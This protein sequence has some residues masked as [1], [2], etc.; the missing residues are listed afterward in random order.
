MTIDE[1]GPPRMPPSTFPGI[2]HYLS[3]KPIPQERDVVALSF[4]GAAVRWLTVLAAVGL[5]ITAIYLIIQGVYG[6]G[7][8]V[9]STL[10][11]LATNSLIGLLV[12]VLATAAIQSSSTTTT[13]TVAAVGSGAVPVAVAVPVILGANIGTTITALIVSFSYV[14]RR[15][16][17][18][19]AFGAASLHAGFNILFVAVMLPLELLFHPLQR[20]SDL[21]S[22]LLV[23]EGAAATATGGVVFS[24][25][26]PVVDLI[27]PQGLLGALFAPR[28]AALASIVLGTVLVLVAVRTLGAQLRTLMAAKTS[29]LIKRSSGASDV[30]GVATGTLVTMGVQA[31]SVTVSSLGP[32]AAAQTLKPR[33]LLTITLGANVGTT[34]MALLTALAVPGSLGSFA[35]QAA[36]I[37]VLFN[38]I[39]TV[40][41]LSIRPVRELL[42]SL[43]QF[44]GRL[45]S[46]SYVAAGAL[47]A[48]FYLV[49]PAVILL[50]YTALG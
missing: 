20:L 40:L 6:M 26:S 19:R 50:A 35:V 23:G 7:A 33:E 11:D 41:V 49:I 31:S 10:F 18:Q 17:F 13:L 46:G 44:S 38:T 39:G 3:P 25:F 34:F 22:D 48:A 21:L 27:G 14:G 43:A 28:V 8:G 32:F 1:K 42:I 5:M 29:S 37:H 4:L 36:L 45:A 12:G 47:L 24:V 2:H 16:E 30:L 9:V 15:L